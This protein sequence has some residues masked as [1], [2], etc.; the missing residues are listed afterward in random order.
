[1]LANV[2]QANAQVSQVENFVW[3]QASVNNYQN[4][5][6]AQM[7]ETATDFFEYEVACGKPADMTLLDNAVNVVFMAACGMATQRQ[8]SLTNNMSQEAYNIWCQWAN[9]ALQIEDTL[10]RYFASKTQMVNPRQQQQHRQAPQ[11]PQWN[12]PQQNGWDTAHSVTGNGVNANGQWGAPVGSGWNQPQQ[13]PAFRQQA[14]MTP[15]R[16]NTG[17]FSRQRAPQQNPM[18]QRQQSNPDSGMVRRYAGSSLVRKEQPAQQQQASRQQ[19]QAP[20]TITPADDNQ[21]YQFSTPKSGWRPR[22]NPNGPQPFNPANN[23]P[24]GRE[25]AEQHEAASTA[26]GSWDQSTIDWDNPNDTFG[27]EYGQ[28]AQST[29]TQNH[30]KTP[31]FMDRISSNK[32][33]PNLRFGL[34][35]EKGMVEFTIADWEKGPK[36]PEFPWEL[37]Y[38]PGTHTR[39]IAYDLKRKCF[40]QLLEEN[41]VKYDDH[42]IMEQSITVRKNAATTARHEQ[43]LGRDFSTLDTPKVQ[44]LTNL[45]TQKQQIIDHRLAA[46]QEKWD[47]QEEFAV[48]EAKEPGKS[49]VAPELIPSREDAVAT[50]LD[51]ETDEDLATAEGYL[52]DDQVVFIDKKA[53]YLSEEHALYATGAELIANGMSFAEVP[54]TVTTYAELTPYVLPENDDSVMEHLL[55]L[56]SRTQIKSLLELGQ[57]MK[58]I[59]TKIPT[60][61]WTLINDQMTAYVNSILDIELAARVD[62][63]SFADD[64]AEI[65]KYL[66]EKRGEKVLQ[67]LSRHIQEFMSVLCCVIPP[68]MSEKSFSEITANIVSDYNEEVADRTVFVRRPTVLAKLNYTSLEL[69]VYADTSKFVVTDSSSPKLFALLKLILKKSS[70]SEETAGFFKRVLLL[71]DGAR[72]TIHEGWMGDGSVIILKKA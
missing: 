43:G 2:I 28:P 56:T 59:A 11:Q 58:S 22:N 46:A 33:V 37:G 69:N 47:K 60:Y 53:G 13:Q 66:K 31:Q 38:V 12:Q 35:T 70:D 64:I 45:I 20:E 17:M 6:F 24:V 10:N 30:S 63:D 67:Q 18:T 32:D 3:N 44:T 8:P 55:P 54:M 49:Y 15:V 27:E 39:R 14:P 9:T 72:F 34:E 36:D 52:S 21:G 42:A 29:V 5:Y 62:I 50:P 51:S 57:H 65:P 61:L 1:M 48:S 41:T 25:V 7:V 40:I 71:E 23:P 68:D 16:P 19:Y 26:S 4:P